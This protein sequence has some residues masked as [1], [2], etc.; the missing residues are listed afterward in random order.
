MKKISLLLIASI[1][2][3]F[4]ACT[5][6]QDT[7]T[8]KDSVEFHT[9]SGAISLQSLYNIMTTSTRYISLKG[10][11]SSFVGKMQ[12]KGLMTDI[13]TEAKMLNWIRVNISRTTFA[14]YNQAELEWNNIKSESYT[15]T[16]ENLEFFSALK[17]QANP[18]NSY[19]N[20]LQPEYQIALSENPCTKACQGAF[21]STVNSAAQTYSNA[22]AQAMA[23]WISVNIQST[24]NMNSTCSSA[25]IN[26]DIAIDE[27]ANTQQLCLA[28]CNN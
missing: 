25:R 15:V 28:G 2:I 4:A 19:Y 14:S 21:L 27:A 18:S 8:S 24:N 6:E 17:A 13:N 16:T 23:S 10:L 1:F 5:N 26:F 20:L 22:V 7:V 3:G 9:K 11:R 12:F